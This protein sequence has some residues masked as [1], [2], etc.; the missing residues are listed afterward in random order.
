MGRS[1][2]LA[3]IL[4]DAF[5]GRKGFQVDVYPG[6]ET[7]GAATANHRGAMDHHTGPGSYNDLLNY[8][9][10]NSSISPLCNVATSRPQDGIVRITVVASGK[11]NHAG[12]GELPWT[13]KDGGNVAAIGFEN[14]NDGKQEWPEQ[15]NE[16]IAIANIACINKMGVGVDRVADHRTYTSR[17][18]DRVHIDIANWRARLTEMM[19]G[20]DVPIAKHGDSGAVVVRIQK[21]INALLTFSNLG[22][23]DMSINPKGGHGVTVDGA[24]GDATARA[25][26]DVCQQLAGVGVTGM[27][28]GATEAYLFSRYGFY[29]DDKRHVALYPHGD[30]EH[31]HP[32]ALHRHTVPSTLTGPAE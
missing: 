4:A 20:A 21:D 8:M 23:A 7:R 28:F 10:E 16:A 19:T 3:D 31:S 2:W 24:Y 13:G 11:A 27:E 12:V 30:T 1:L 26:A 6:W 18:V 5:R 32:V 25:I 9:A 29:A 17:K 14:Q 22:P 15:Q